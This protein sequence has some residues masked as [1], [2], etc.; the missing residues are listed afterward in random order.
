[1]ASANVK[2]VDKFDDL[3]YT[4]NDIFSMVDTYVNKVYDSLEQDT[5]NVDN[6][7]TA[8]S[9]L[10][11]VVVIGIAKL[12]AHANRIKPQQI[13]TTW[14]ADM[15][16]ELQ[17]DCPDKS[18]NDITKEDWSDLKDFSVDVIYTYQSDKFPSVKADPQF[19]YELGSYAQPKSDDGIHESHLEESNRNSNSSTPYESESNVKSEDGPEKS[20]SES[21][22]GPEKS[23]YEDG[24]EKSES[25]SEDGPEK[26]EYE[27]GPEKSES[28]VKSEDG[29]KKSEY[30]DGPEKY[31]SESESESEYESEPDDE[32][33]HWDM[34]KI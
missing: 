18:D 22:D 1:M 11:H 10:E 12:K 13:N 27:D 28:N 17:T 23:E 9:L 26:S 29:P 2:N 6:Y 33:K 14:R 24:P 4:T 25:E 8:I 15:K 32:F 19:N 7:F 16:K 5:D 3:C 20:E 21:E 34:C 31:E 30:E